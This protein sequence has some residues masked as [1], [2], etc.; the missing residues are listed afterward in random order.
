M[1]ISSSITSLFNYLFSSSVKQGLKDSS[2]SMFILGFSKVNLLVK[3]LMKTF[4]ISSSS[5]IIFLLSL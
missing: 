2:D 1:Q 3:S 5:S 4:E